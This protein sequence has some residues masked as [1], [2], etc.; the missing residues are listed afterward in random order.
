M[1][2]QDFY[3]KFNFPDADLYA[4]VVDRLKHAQ[5]DIKEF[6]EFGLTMSKLKGIQ[7]RILQ[8]YNL[9]NDDELVGNQ[10]IVT[11][12]KYDKANLLK[13][14]IRAVMMR[15]A[16]KYGLRSG[17]YLGLGSSSFSM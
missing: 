11:E 12:K 6:N 1:R 14:A 17:R 15:V 13:A 8:F 9:P 10:M 16:I 3:R 7:N 4:M 2:K 5:R